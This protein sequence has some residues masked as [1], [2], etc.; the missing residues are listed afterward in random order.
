MEQI[1]AKNVKIQTVQNV[2]IKINVPY[3]T[4]KMDLN[5]RMENVSNNVPKIIMK[6]EKRN[7]LLKELVD[8]DSL[9]FSAKNVIHIVLPVN[10]EMYIDTDHVILE[11]VGI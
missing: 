9:I 1:H 10:K 5:Q 3:V 11:D 8:G 7:F 4:L 2:K 6:F